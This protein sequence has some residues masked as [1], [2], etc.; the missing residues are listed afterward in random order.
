MKKGGALLDVTIGA[1]DGAEIWELV[2]LFILC[3]FQQLNKIINFGLY[4]DDGLAVVKNMSG[5]QSEKVKKEW[6]ELVKE[7]ALNLIIECN[8]TTVDYLDITLN[9]FDGTYKRYQKSENTSHYSHK[10][11]NHP[12][13]IIK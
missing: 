13:N 4:R 12:P 9:L 10:E 2:G 1:Y 11:S 3:K 8:K 6:Q 5:P 7:F